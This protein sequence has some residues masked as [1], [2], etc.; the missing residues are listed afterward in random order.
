MGMPAPVMIGVCCEPKPVNGDHRSDVLLD[1]LV[2]TVGSPGGR[3]ARLPQMN[4]DQ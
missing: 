3:R 1:H 2:R 4:A